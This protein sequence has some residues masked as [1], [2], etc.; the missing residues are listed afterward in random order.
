MSINDRKFL[1]PIQVQRRFGIKSE[2]YNRF[3]DAGFPTYTCAGVTRHPIDEIYMW[4]E[5]NRLQLEDQNNLC[6]R[7]QIMAL[8]NIN[9]KILEDWEKCGLPKRLVCNHRVKKFL[10]HK[11][12]VIDWLRS[13]S[14]VVGVL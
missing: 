3:I 11:Q 4:C 8:L 5:E 7:S 2:E 1:S 9:S 13:Q 12:D 10:Y 6:S 14:S